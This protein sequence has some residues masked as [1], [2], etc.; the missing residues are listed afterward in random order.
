MDSKSLRF[1]THQA[2]FSAV[3]SGDLEKIIQAVDKLTQDESGDGSSLS[4][5][6]AVQSDY[7]ETA[8]YVAA[9]NNLEDVFGYLLRFCDI[10][11]VKIRS[12][13]D[14]DVFHAAAKRG[15]LGKQSNSDTVLSLLLS[16]LG[17]QFY[18]SSFGFLCSLDF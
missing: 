1:I 9:K 16:N 10:H 11:T 5:L 2:F 8:L 13:S 12:K 3:E 7:G 15:H 6:M 17:P 4:D 18:L 14:M